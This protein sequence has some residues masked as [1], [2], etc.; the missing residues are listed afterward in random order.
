MKIV[1]KKSLSVVFAI[2]MALSCFATAFAADTVLNI[3]CTTDDANGI[4]YV[5]IP[6]Y[7][8]CGNITLSI[9]PSTSKLTLIGDVNT[10][11][12]A[13]YVNAVAGTTYT[14]TASSSVEKDGVTTTYS[15]SNTVTLKKSKAAP[16]SITVD[17]T[18]NSITV[19]GVN[20]NTVTSSSGLEFELTTKVTTKDESGKDVKTDKV[21][22]KWGSTFTFTGLD[23]GT[24]YYVH[25]RYAETKD[26][27][28]S[29]ERIQ[30]FRT[31]TES[32]HTVNPVI[33]TNVT[34]NT[35]TVEAQE[36]YR[37]SKDN[38]KSWQTSNEFKNL[39]SG[40]TYFI[41]Q[42]YV[43]PDGAE[44][45]SAL[46]EMVVVQTNSLDVYTAKFADAKIEGVSDGA[47]VSADSA[48]TIKAPTVT[49]SS[50]DKNVQWGDTR[51]VAN[52]LYVNDDDKGTFNNGSISVKLSSGTQK[53]K[54]TYKQQIYKNG[55]VD[56]GAKEET[57]TVTVT[58]STKVQKIFSVI[59]NQLPELIA[60]A[61]KWLME[62]GLSIIIFF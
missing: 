53:I 5:S 29:E 7:E 61:I 17:R 15:G 43:D 18:T 55:W 13:T 22:Y 44:V 2:I 23:S 20:N 34:K 21:V 49:R 16:T 14:V 47:K 37:Y 6:M 10:D 60:K 30:G 27:I 39:T 3:N 40:Q 38:G 56:T 28:A 58:A 36:N 1:V 4:I 54:V 9:T 62:K 11:G 19:T 50:D 25:A 59:T 42:K 52:K 48:I 24:L 8:E 32:T 51:Y 41:T 35:I 33:L 46:A 26:Y 12:K 31:L 45:D 57:K